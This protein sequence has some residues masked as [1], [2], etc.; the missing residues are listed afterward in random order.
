MGMVAG[1][2]FEIFPLGSNEVYAF[3]DKFGANYPQLVIDE[4]ISLIYPF[5]RFFYVNKDNE[6]LANKIQTGLEKA[7]DD[8]SLQNL[9]NQ[10]A[11]FKDA[12]SKAHLHNRVQIRIDTPNLTSAFPTF[13]QNGGI[14][15]KFV[16]SS[17]C[18]INLS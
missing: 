4:H 5:G 17:S 8:G 1:K 14:R 16:A 7:L 18:S 12:F 9:L 3:L 11:Y 13:R 6:E 10:H 2:R 15:H